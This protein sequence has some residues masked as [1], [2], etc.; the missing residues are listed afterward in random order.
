MSLRTCYS[1][2]HIC[3]AL[4]TVEWFSITRKWE[5]NELLVVRKHSMLD[6]TDYSLICNFIWVIYSVFQISFI[7]LIA[8]IMCNVQCAM[9]LKEHQ[10]TN[11]NYFQNRECRVVL[12]TDFT[13]YLSLRCALSCIIWISYCQT[14]QQVCVCVCVCV[15][16]C[17]CVCTFCVRLH[18]C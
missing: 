2:L 10:I 1:I 9:K 8:C 12:N 18:I 17:V 7:S 6:R 14:A 4:L 15:H 13:R 3:H 11:L 5:W 16:V